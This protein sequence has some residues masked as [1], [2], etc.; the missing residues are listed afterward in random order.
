MMARLD[1]SFWRRGDPARLIERRERLKQLELARAIFKLPEG[2]WETKVQL[3][4]ADQRPSVRRCLE[5]LKD[6]RAELR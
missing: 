6:H 3:L 4:P 5:I 1:L 2:E